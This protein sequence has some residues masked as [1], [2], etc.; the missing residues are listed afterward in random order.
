MSIRLSEVKDERLRER[1]AKACRDQDSARV[2]RLPHAEQCQCE[3]ALG[4]SDAREAQGTGCPHCRFTLKR[5]KLLDIDAK[6]ASTKDLLDGLAL[7]RIIPGDREGQITLEVN[8]VKVGKYSDECTV[9]EIEN[10]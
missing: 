10:L 6:Y 7:A 8:Q 9:I 2:G 4:G 5:V 3:E 1:I